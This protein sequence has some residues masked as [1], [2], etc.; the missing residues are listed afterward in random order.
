MDQP[1]AIREQGFET[2]AGLRRGSAL[3]ARSEG[4]RSRPDGDI[5]HPGG[6]FR[7]VW[8]TRRM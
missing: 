2:G 7:E 3:E 5:G 8:S 1:L 4:E 6:H